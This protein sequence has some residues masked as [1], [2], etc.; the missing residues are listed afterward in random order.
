M[1]IHQLRE[2]L[3]GTYEKLFS[4]QHTPEDVDAYI[5]ACGAA[6][7]RDEMSAEDFAYEV[8]LAQRMKEKN[9]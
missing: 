3:G 2:V 8:D 9:L 6:R 4:R 5:A 7:L 1:T